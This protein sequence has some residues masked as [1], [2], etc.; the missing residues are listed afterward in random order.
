MMLDPEGTGGLRPMPMDDLGASA[1][2]GEPDAALRSMDVDAKAT[3][4]DANIAK[5]KGGEI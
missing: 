4:A 1:A 2:G 5:P 3:T